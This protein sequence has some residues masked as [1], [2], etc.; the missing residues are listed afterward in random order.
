MRPGWLMIAASLGLTMTVWAESVIDPRMHEDDDA[1]MTR[2]AEAFLAEVSATIAKVPP[3]L[4]E[5]R[6][7]RLAL[8][9]VDAVLHD[10]YAPNRAPVQTFY[11]SRIA[12]AVEEIESAKVETGARV[13]KLYNHGFV[14]RTPSVTLGFDIHRGA[15]GFRVN[16][17]DKGRTMV[18]APDFPIAIDLV[19]RLAA[20]CDV[21]FISHLHGDHADEDVAQAFVDLGKPVVTPPGVFEGKPIY[22]KLLRMERVAE[23]RQNLPI[24]EGKQTL[25]VIVYPGQQYQ[26]GGVPNNVVLVYTPEGLGIAHNGDQINDPYP[27]YQEDFKWIDK[28]K[29]HQR[30]DILMTNCWTNDILRLVR[31]FNPKLVLPGHENEVGHP[32]WDRVPYW[33]DEDYLNLNYSETKAEFSVLPMVWGESYKY[34]PD[35]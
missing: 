2:Q 3:Q 30:V 24:Q 17:P 19:K 25:E 33:G 35:R 31:G 9:L 15:R 22:D 32:L 6:E 7:R 16:T 34:Q 5:P 21:L 29:E 8:L 13:W 20:Q 26:G 1:Y 27:D 10:Q 11:A 18:P 28:V 23:L 14:V 4:P 12:K